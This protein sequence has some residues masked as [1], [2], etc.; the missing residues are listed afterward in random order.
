MLFSL[1]NIYTETIATVNSYEI[2]LE[3]LQEKMQDYEGD[4]DL[5]FFQ[6]RELALEDLINEQIIVIYAEENGITVD[7]NEVESYFINLLGN[8]PKLLTD[9]EFDPQKF[10]NLKKTNQ[11]RKILAEM[12]RDI[13]ISKTGSLIQNNFAISDENLLQQFILENAE[14]DIS[15]ALINVDAANVP[16]TFSPTNAFHFYQK[17]KRNFL[18]DKEIKL[19]FFIVP[20]KEF[21]DY[22]EST[23]DDLI[24][25]FISDDS[26]FSEYDLDSLKSVFME[27]EINRLCLN[28]AKA[29]KGLV[30]LNR[31]IP[32]PML[33]TGFMKENDI[34]GKIPVSVIKNA[35]KIWENHFS[36]PVELEIGFLVYEVKE[37]KKPVKTNLKNVYEKVWKAYIN[38]EKNKTDISG[39]KQYFRNNIDQ[40][41]VPAA[42][43]RKIFIPFEDSIL[44]TKI[45]N[46]FK[47]KD[48]LEKILD[49]NDLKSNS[50]V[51]YLEKYSNSF[52]IDEEI[53]T[54]FQNEK[55]FGTIKEDD[56][57]VFYHVESYFP[58][59]IPDYD[60]I[61]SQV[62]NQIIVPE[63]DT[64]D[65]RGYYQSHLQNFMS[66]DSLR[67][68]GVFIPFEPDS[69]EIFSDS[70]FQYYQNNR[71]F[72][73]RDQSV[74]F[75]YIFH[76]NRKQIEKIYDQLL[77][78]YDFEILQYCFSE[79][80]IYAQ[81]EI[82]SV[83]S[84]PPEIQNAFLETPVHDFT[85][86]VY[87]DNGWL[88]LH[89]LE[90]YPAGIPGF[91]ELEKSISGKLKLEEAK[92]IAQLKAESIFDSTTYFSNCY[93]FAE[94]K[95][96]F[97]SDFREADSEFNK[98]G[99][100]EKYKGELLRLWNN[101]KY[102]G[103]ITTDKG[104]AVIFLL[105]KK[106]AEQLPFKDALPKIKK[107]FNAKKRF[108]TAHKFSLHLRNKI[109]T[110]VNADSLLFFFGG[111]KKEKHLTFES[112]IPL[113]KISDRILEDISKR[114]EGYF[115]PIIKT[116]DNHLMFYH[117][118]RMQKISREAFESQKDKFKKHII[119]KEFSNW[120]EEF[121]AKIEIK[122]KF[123]E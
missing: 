103:L 20:K 29:M 101:E 90:E 46:N 10:E 67:I 56:H 21:K 105:Q 63:A 114:K 64:T 117:I 32:Y 72:F 3:Q 96:I 57:L 41:I 102:S 122:T 74:R 123:D 89:K 55:D 120:L 80:S 79:D 100:I 73:Y 30:D 87:I 91:I 65:F 59:F 76:N 39:L 49:E 94:E 88:I 61:K 111:W 69:I 12:R 62:R 99:S 19:R 13:L 25:P 22:V 83:K 112:E 23:I 121:K 51:I 71:D 98:I 110:G 4:F 14:V 7:E 43:T 15:Y 106:I 9:G 82:V 11:V 48:E 45:K 34:L 28:K 6:I 81:N 75:Q 5:T 50:N 107:I 118:D 8:D 17:N 70:I 92:K 36:E 31:M 78:G 66:P 85:E 60:D 119:E 104:C 115:S 38:K 86:P 53:A 18:S 54:D 93:R 44:F 58:E 35:F 52:P 68:G 77:A 84:L 27:K 37:I 109:I 97:K 47:R 2:T 108:D 26:T 42:Y 33:E 116:S 40:F 24:A 16:V 95:Y 113:I 1:I